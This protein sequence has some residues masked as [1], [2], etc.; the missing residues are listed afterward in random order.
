M[1]N[2]ISLVITIFIAVLCVNY[3]KAHIS[4]GLFR[5]IKRD[6]IIWIGFLT[7]TTGIFILIRKLIA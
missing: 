2:L 6:Y 5:L 4:P 7:F 1:H 3:V